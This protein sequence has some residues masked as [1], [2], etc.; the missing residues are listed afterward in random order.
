MKRNLYNYRNF[1]LEDSLF[2][3]ATKNQAIKEKVKIIANNEWEIFLAS[4]AK[5]L[6]PGNV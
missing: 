5:E 1:S 3:N 4:R 2:P 6:V